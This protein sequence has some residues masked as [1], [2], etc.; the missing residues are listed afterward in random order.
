MEVTE[1]VLQ[2]LADMAESVVNSLEAGE[3]ANAL[4]RARELYTELSITEED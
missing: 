1:E 2:L 3:Y 4:A